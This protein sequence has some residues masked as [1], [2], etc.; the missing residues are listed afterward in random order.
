VEEEYRDIKPKPDLFERKSV[1]W[2][3]FGLIPAL[4]FVLV[5][6]GIR[7]SQYGIDHTILVFG[8][9][10]LVSGRPAAIRLSL[11]ADDGRFFLP[12]ELTGFLKKGDER[13]LLF[14]GPVSDR[15]QALGR[16]FKVPK[17]P[18]GKYELE[19]DFHFDKRQRKVRTP[20]NIVGKAPPESLAVPSDTKI[21]T[22]LATVIKGETEVQALPE[23]RGTPTGIESVV[24]VRTV[25]DQG[26]P[27][28]TDLEMRL[29][30]LEAPLKEQTD[31]L[32]L[33]AMTVKPMELSIPIRVSGARKRDEAP[34][35]SK[36]DASAKDVDAGDDED[37]DAYL[38]PHVVY[39]GISATLNNPVAAAGDPVSL[40]VEQVSNG[41]PLY[42]DLFHEG[43]LVSAS[44]GWL[45]G[46]R[47]AIDVKPTL[48]GLYR[49]QLSTTPFSPD[50]ALAVRHFYV[51][52]D[53]EDFV[54][55]LRE[56][57]ARL[58]ESE[59]DGAWARA[60]L[61]MPLERAQGFKP[62]LA[63]AFA[64]SRLY[65]G[66]RAPARLVSS[67]LKDDQELNEFK[68][69][70]QRMVMVAIIALGLGV[71]LLVA[72]FAYTA[73][74]RQ[75][76]ISQMI[77]SEPEDS[78]ESDEWSPP[79]IRGGAWRMAV[80]GAILLFIVLGAFVAI[81]LLVDTLTWRS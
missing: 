59:R 66:H 3:L 54:A 19:L 53:G 24:F 70:F 16:D 27:F 71:S 5:C 65:N 35:T 62:A 29:P 39:S 43:R 60:V 7:V 79:A 64:L 40:T 10:V 17:I 81:A 74:Q 46:Q 76:R 67:R 20:V 47:A 68:E 30:G 56:V 38:H 61:E 4:V 14:G 58:T 51:L 8:D 50:K 13:Y 12:E 21:E 57:L 78:E 75:Q 72:L 22:P 1:R 26:T 55:G 18:S 69:G 33:L 23:D 42:V 36:P 49:L 15:G 25:S 45:S 73:F 28:S 77:L 52:D 2:T 31:T 9:D 34:K 32:G 6:A 37:K 63:A 41:G 80:Q 11:M 44:S 48:P